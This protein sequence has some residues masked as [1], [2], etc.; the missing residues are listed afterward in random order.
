MD[1]VPD[2][3]EGH[4]GSRDRFRFLK[5]LLGG[6]LLVIGLG[7]IWSSFFTEVLPVF[8]QELDALT[9]IAILVFFFAA[10]YFFVS[11]VFLFIFKSPRRSGDGRHVVDGVDIK[12]DFKLNDPATHVAISMLQIVVAAVL[13]TVAVR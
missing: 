2:K 1:Q 6:Q 9:R 5:Y 13:L 3:K 12:I 7:V 8:R 4:R 11:L 10:G